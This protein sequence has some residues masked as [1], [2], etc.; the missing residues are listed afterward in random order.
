MTAPDDLSQWQDRL[1]AALARHGLASMSVRIFRETASTQDAAKAFTPGPALVVA[2]R[3]TAGRG[4]LGRSW[5][6]APGAAVLMSIVWPIDMQRASHDRISM[7]A[8][9]AVAQAVEAIV[10]SAAVRIKW[11]NDVVIDGRKLAGILIES[12]KDACVIGIGLNVRPVE[13]D[14]PVIAASAVSLAELGARADRPAVI[15]RIAIALHRV[16][17]MDDPAEALDAWR[18]RAVLGQTQ[19]FEHHRR[20]IT[21]QIVDLDPDHGLIVRRDS[22]EMVTLPAATTSV[23]K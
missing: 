10:P 9:L 3:Q 12:V 4:R 20:S 13:T 14:D 22:G 5:Q 21:G 7:L 16:I 23:V 2:D 6:A 8:G 15:E 1:E 17:E 18:C 11:P 19:T